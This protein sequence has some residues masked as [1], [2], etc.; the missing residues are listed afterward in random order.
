MTTP[1]PPPP[2][3][4]PPTFRAVLGDAYRSRRQLRRRRNHNRTLAAAALA[5]PAVLAAWWAVGQRIDTTV[6]DRLGA[7]V[8]THIIPN[9]D[10]AIAARVD[11]AR[12]EIGPT[13]VAA[14]P[15][16][17][18]ACPLTPD[19]QAIITMDPATG[20]SSLH[21]QR[22]SKVDRDVRQVLAAGATLGQLRVT[23]PAADQL[24]VTTTPTA[25]VPLFACG[26]ATQA[27]G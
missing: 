14:A 4:E 22:G 25:G 18:A 23:A 1:A 2:P 3:P 12:T 19:A 15:L 5:V 24:E 17:W 26:P 27:A 8:D 13:V 16:A 6:N 20:F 11:Q 9:L 7:V 21:P 10:R